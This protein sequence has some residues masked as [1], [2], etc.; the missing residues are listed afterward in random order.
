MRIRNPFAFRPYPVTI[1][2]SVIYVA[3]FIALLTIHTVTPSA[4]SDS[5]EAEAVSEA[6]HDL[7]TLTKTFHPYNSRAN[8]QVRD[9]LL[10]RVDAV[11]AHKGASASR[12]KQHGHQRFRYTNESS[13]VVVFSDTISNASFST[14]GSPIDSGRSHKAGTS[15]YFEGTNIIVY[16]RGSDDDP[17]D[18]WVK[19]RAP[20][21]HGGVLINAHYDSVSTG[22]G[23]TDD[24]TG[25]VTILQI[26][27]RFSQPQHRPKKGIV[28]LFN[29]GE[30]DFLNGARAFCQ[31]PMS[32]IVT[33]FLNL[34]GAGAGGRATLFRSTDLEVTRAY[35]DSRYP[36]GTVLS[37]DAFKRGIIRSQTDYVIFSELL[38]L[39]GLDVAFMEPRARYHTDQDDTRHTNRNSVWHMLS[40]SMT[41][42][43]GLSSN[44]P[45]ERQRSNA[46]W[47]DLFGRAF[48]A[49][50]LNTLFALSVA[51]LVVAP[52]TLFIVGLFLLKTN[53]FYLFS[54]S[55]HHHHPEG[56]DSVPLSGWRGFFRF[57]M[58]IVA[59]SAA[60]VAL[61]YLITKLNP[62]IVYSS[63][64]AIWSML[65]SAWFFAAWVLL[66]AADFVRPSALQRTYTLLWMF[67]VQWVILVVATVL[68][69]GPKIA[70]G[71]LI[72]FYFAGTFLATFIGFLELFGLSRKAV[73]ADELSNTSAHTS[74]TA[75]RPGTSSGN[76]LNAPEEGT[77]HGSDDEQEPSES[78]SLLRGNQHQTSHQPSAEDGNNGH[79]NHGLEGSKADRVYGYEQPW[80][81]SLPSWVWFLQFLVTAP[82]AVILF[83]QAALL[84]SSAT[85]QTLADG[86]SP[87]RVY[88]GMALLSI[89][90]LAPLSPYLHRYT[91]HIPTFLFLVFIGTLAYNIFT[92][93]FSNNNR[94][95]L[96]FIQRVDL[97]TGLNKA[98]LTGVSGGYL[99]QSISNLPSATSQT[100]QC[101]PSELRKG[102]TE[103]S[104]DGLAPAVV[105]ST[106]P[107]IP[108]LFGYSDWLSYNVTRLSKNE[109]RFHLWGRDTR[110]CKI[111]FHKPIFDFAVKGAA[112]QDKRLQRVPKDGS[113]ELRLWSRTWEKPW[114]VTVEWEDSGEGSADHNG[115]DGR[116][117]C[118]WSDNNEPGLIPALDEI[119]HFAP[120]WVAVSKLGDGLVEGSKAFVI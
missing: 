117:V 99:Q 28:A 30:E 1:L 62:Y 78:T 14:Q 38:G 98:S 80:S 79:H 94:L 60:V 92:F 11:L 108:P 63:Q 114:E 90:I 61:S 8:D 12:L 85:S 34:E 109:A 25:I 3:L 66:R 23:A 104:W 18:W 59:S 100:I 24:G 119:S 120:D 2:A 29:N 56:D 86:N 5:S 111:E 46:V 76:H 19:K 87:A 106:H 20:K 51:L 55:M 107:G 37:G 82:I 40:A 73:Y 58:T 118:L 113:K 84:Y 35:S 7:Q 54:A 49:F 89:F 71:Y 81:W 53:R 33:S 75:S 112:R 91:Y 32:R 96:F 64:Y 50:S 72:M 27:K 102:L 17:D 45:N 70:S 83:G 74:Q 47:F 39:R 65:L 68:E 36:F 43:Q 48:A 4:P 15:V 10:Q 105:K 6:W 21:S 41:T 44:T 77:G 88:L 101:S 110:A 31:H 16:I 116:I 26:I 57:P 13:P 95:K 9:W 103:C 52:L 93:P 22:F 67:I 115:M 42:I 97:D 69:R